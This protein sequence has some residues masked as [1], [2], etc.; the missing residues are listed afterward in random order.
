[1]IVLIQVHAK[2]VYISILASILVSDSESLAPE[3]GP[4]SAATWFTLSKTLDIWPEM[5]YLQT[6]NIPHQG[7]S[8]AGFLNF[9]LMTCGGGGGVGRGFVLCVLRYLTSQA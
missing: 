9:T 5:V 4:E 3:I 1:M 2:Q 6:C 7:C 8:K